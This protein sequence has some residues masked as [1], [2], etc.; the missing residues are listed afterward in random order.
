MLNSSPPISTPPHFLF[1]SIFSYVV[2]RLCANIVDRIHSSSA[3]SSR[4]TSIARASSSSPSHL[5]GGAGN[6]AVAPPAVPAV[7]CASGF[8]SVGFATFLNSVSTG[9]MFSNAW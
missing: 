6:A 1:R 5:F 4:L 3:S 2:L 7:S 9:Y 8:S